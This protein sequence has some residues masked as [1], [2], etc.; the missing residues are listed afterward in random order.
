MS[1]R[2][3]AIG[4]VAD[5]GRPLEAGAPANLVLVDPSVE[6]TV[7]PQES[8]SLSRNTPFDGMTLPG[9][10]VAT[11]L[12]RYGDR[13]GRKAGQ[14]KAVPGHS[15]T[16][17]ILAA[18]YYGMYRGWRNRKSRQADLAP[19]PA[20]PDDKTAASKVCTSRPP[21]PATGWT[22]SPCTNWASAVPR[23]WPS[24]RPA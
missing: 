6:K 17:L 11:F 18:A 21:R 7:V 9:K 12:Q 19:L 13:P 1:Y 15:G 10:V 14:V 23:T 3:A 22:G 20:V 5:H 16:L 4:Q 8:A 2:P 24:V